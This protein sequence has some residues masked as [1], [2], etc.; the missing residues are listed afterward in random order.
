LPHKPSIDVFGA[1]LAPAGFVLLWSTGFIVARAAAP[2]ADLSLF[3]AGRFL[4]AALLLAILA[5]FGRRVWPQGQ[6]LWA[7][8][9]IGALMH[10][11][12][13]VTG[14]AAIRMGL[15][16]GIMAL[17]GGL[18]PIVAAA[19]ATLLGARP[20]PRLWLGLCLAFLGLGLTIA[21]GLWAAT[22]AAVSFS[23]LGLAFTGVLSLSL[24]AVAQERIGRGDDL[25]A[26]SSLQHA[27]GAGIAAVA[28]L[29]FGTLAWD[30][31]LPLWLAFG[32]ATVGISLCAVGLLITLIRRD[33]AARTSALLLLVP[34]FAALQGWLLFG[35]R[36]GALQIAGFLLAL[37]GVWLARKPQAT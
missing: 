26:V 18:Q 13:L 35:E 32:W 8:L 36:L 11:L 14:Y 21:P 19:L 33:G 27:G 5:A 10:G 22:G 7:H 37:A 4:L 12:Y 3:L 28:T 6:R 23:A 9:G 1:L 15:A 17:I 30:N 34:P 2:H 20:T 25:V 24:A 29:V 16:V 31:A